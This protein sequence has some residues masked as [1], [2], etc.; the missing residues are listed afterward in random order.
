MRLEALLQRGRAQ[1]SA[2]SRYPL[3]KIRR[4]PGASTGPRSVE[5]GKGPVE[6]GTTANRGA[7][8]GPRSVERGKENQRIEALHKHRGFNGAALSRAR[9][10]VR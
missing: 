1:S 5:R 10:D 8:T 4:Q 7:S 3:E 2:E 9:K 6:L